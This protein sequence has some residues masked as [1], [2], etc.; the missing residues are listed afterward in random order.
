MPD[1]WRKKRRPT[2]RLRRDRGSYFY[3]RPSP[4][5]SALANRTQSAEL[6]KTL[7]RARQKELVDS[8]ILEPILHV[9]GPPA[10]LKNRHIRGQPPR[11][12]PVIETDD[13]LAQT[14]RPAKYR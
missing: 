1:R 12:K 13:H 3:L 8:K 5:N 4:E 10:T 2:E 7:H 9:F 6:R 14:P 11:T